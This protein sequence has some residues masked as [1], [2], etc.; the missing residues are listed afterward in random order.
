MAQVVI[1]RSGNVLQV[2]PA[3]ADILGPVLSYSHR[4][5]NYDPFSHKKD[6]SFQQREL[7]RVDAGNLY[8][9]QGALTLITTT[10]TQAGIT[11]EYI[12]SRPVQELVPDYDYLGTCMPELEFRYKQDEILATLIVQNSGV[13]V[14]PTAYGKTFIM[15]ALAALYPKANIIMASPS[16]ALLRGTYRRMLGIAPDVGRV[17][18]GQHSPARITLATFNSILHA[19]VQKCDILLIDE[20]HKLGAPQISANIAKIRSPVKIFGMTATPQGRSDGAE[21]ITEMLIGPVICRLTYDEAANEGIIANMKVVLMDMEENCCDT[22]SGEYKTKPAKKRWCYWRN[23]VRNSRFANA[24]NT[25]PKKMGIRD[26]PQILVLCETIEHAFRMKKF[27]PDFDVVYAGMNGDRVAKLKGAKLVPDDFKPLTASQRDK[28]LRGFEDGTLRRVIATGCWGEGVDFVELDVL[29]N[30]SG[31]PSPISTAQWAGRNSRIYEG[32][33]F[34]LVI[35][36]ADQWDVWAS[37]RAK[38]R[39]TT[40][41]KNKWELLKGNRV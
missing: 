12:D 33:Q 35:D 40:Y 18:G 31:E 17:G 2:A 5:L 24:I 10:L 6:M 19:P 32:K 16:T 15:L 41:R 21:L 28:M 9:T 39:C 3:V 7:F 38:R 22:H 14:A 11:Y 25:Y 37:G 8:T 23:D 4:E 29:V 26:N 13:I 34:G 36:S 27:L 30:V 1:R 20:C